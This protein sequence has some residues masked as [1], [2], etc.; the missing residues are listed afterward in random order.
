VAYTMKNASGGKTMA[1]ASPP[2]PPADAPWRDGLDLGAV[3]ISR[4]AIV[5]AVAL[6]EVI[7][8]WLEERVPQWLGVTSAPIYPAAHFIASWLLLL[9]DIAL[10]ATV[11]VKCLNDVVEAFWTA[12]RSRR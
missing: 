3:V 7:V 8:L 9:F 2:S 10:L 12:R 5:A 6:A 4:L 11:A 1:T